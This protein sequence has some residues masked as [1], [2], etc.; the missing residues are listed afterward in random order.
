MYMLRDIIATYEVCHAADVRRPPVSRQ[1]FDHQCVVDLARS[2]CRDDANR[3]IISILVEDATGRGSTAVL[4]ERFAE[5]VSCGR[6]VLRE[7][8]ASDIYPL[9]DPYAEPPQPLANLVVGS[10]PTFALHSA[11]H[12]RIVI[13]P[14]PRCYCPSV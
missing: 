7:V 12:H 3:R 9:P 14:P 10:D 6:L 13:V 1:R 4:H 8:S 2:L 11:D 5:L